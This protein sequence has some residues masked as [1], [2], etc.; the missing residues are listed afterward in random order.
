MKKHLI[1]FCF[2]KKQPRA[3]DEETLAK[4]LQVHDKSTFAGLRDYTFI[5]LT[6]DT[7][8]MPNEASISTLS[9]NSEYRL[10]NSSAALILSFA[11]TCL[12][13]ILALLS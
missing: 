2:T 9:V 11:D 4:L 7:G 1:L 13:I 6:L 10:P 5:V 12:S 8:I 3:C